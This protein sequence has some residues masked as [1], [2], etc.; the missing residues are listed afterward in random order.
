[1]HLIR[2]PNPT[3]ALMDVQGPV[4]VTYVYSLV[5][6]EVRV[7]KVEYR[8]PLE[9]PKP[10]PAQPAAVVSQTTEWFP[11]LLTTCHPLSL[12]REQSLIPSPVAAGDQ[13]Q[14]N[15]FR[16]EIHNATSCA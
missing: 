4:V 14:C 12:P 7:E 6:G 5:D 13:D 1:M 15:I 9:A 10:A 3:F 11:T 16:R 8:K 2:D